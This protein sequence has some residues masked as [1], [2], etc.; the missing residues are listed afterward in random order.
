[1]EV[2]KSRFELLHSD[3]YVVLAMNAGPFEIDKLCASTKK[4]HKLCENPELWR[5]K[6]RNDFPTIFE[7]D[8]REYKD[9]KLEYFILHR[10]DLGFLRNESLRHRDEKIQ[11]LK[12]EIKHIEDEI[13]RVKSMY[14]YEIK[15][16]DEM[17]EKLA[18]KIAI[19]QFTHKTLFTGNAKL[20][21]A[22]KNQKIPDEG[23]IS[24]LHPYYLGTLAK[25]EVIIVNG[26]NG[27][28][29]YFIYIY[30]DESLFYQFSALPS[31]PEEFLNNAHKLGMDLQSFLKLYEIDHIFENSGEILR[32]KH[33]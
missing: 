18:H 6:I 1:M 33:F 25:N 27:I 19:L 2:P 3:H 29:L 23:P 22:I 4:F 14:G 12:D 10:A 7:G 24:E 8:I 31:I 5:E 15:N 30:G 26:Q 11:E 16:I 21:K 17:R 32:I 20:R 9:P 13:S 28:P